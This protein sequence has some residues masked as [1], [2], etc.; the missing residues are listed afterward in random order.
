MNSDF[1]LAEAEKKAQDYLQ[2]DGNPNQIVIVPGK[3]KKYEFGY[4]VQC[5]PKKLLETGDSQKYSVP[6][7][8]PLIVD[9]TDGKVHPIGSQPEDSAIQNYLEKWKALQSTSRKDT[10]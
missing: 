6:G 1:Q 4:V 10:K 2:N 8:G 7:A 5:L 9:S 3:T